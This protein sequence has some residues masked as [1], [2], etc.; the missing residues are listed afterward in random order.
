MTGARNPP[1]P[2]H[3]IHKWKEACKNWLSTGGR[4]EGGPDV[5]QKTTESVFDL[6]PGRCAPASRV[7][8]T[9]YEAGW[10]TWISTSWCC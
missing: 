3:T 4:G 9:G 10:P 5:A 6:T 7:V 1:P 8:A 2:L